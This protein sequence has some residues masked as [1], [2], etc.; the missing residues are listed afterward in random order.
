MCTVCT[1]PLNLIYLLHTVKKQYLTLLRGTQQNHEAVMSL[2]LIEV[3]AY[4]DLVLR[5]AVQI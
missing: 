1:P 2:E 4:L 5:V 3:R